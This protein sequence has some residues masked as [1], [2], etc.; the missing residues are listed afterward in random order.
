LFDK[1]YVSASTHISRLTRGKVPLRAVTCV[2]VACALAAGIVGSAYAFFPPRGAEVVFHFD[3]DS[4]SGFEKV[5]QGGTPEFVLARGST[6]TLTLTLTSREQVPV[7]ATLR[8]GGEVETNFRHWSLMKHVPDGISYRIVPDSLTLEPDSASTVTARIS[9]APG[10]AV[11]SYDLGFWITLISEDRTVD[12][13]RGHSTVLTIVEGA[14][15]INTTTTASST[16]LYVTETA[17]LTTT[18]TTTS[19]AIIE[20]GADPSVYAW[21]V[22]AT[23]TAAALAVAVSLRRRS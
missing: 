1:T 22:G 6:G 10:T 5:V 21:A 3:Y 14:S 15:P 17:T 7:Y 11:R 9:A 8:Y 4:A 16:A 13:G 19:T 2:L 18:A 23:A 20:K 12:V